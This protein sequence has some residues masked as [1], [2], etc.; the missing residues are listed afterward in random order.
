MSAK[1][2]K[3]DKM[4]DKIDKLDDKINKLYE[5]VMKQQQDINELKRNQD[6]DYKIYIA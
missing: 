3:I 2:D 1:I 6:I 5:I 4:S